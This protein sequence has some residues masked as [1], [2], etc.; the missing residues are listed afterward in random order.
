M[1]FWLLKAPW[2]T[3]IFIRIEPQI[4]D[5]E[6][7][8]IIA[9]MLLKCNVS[10]KGSKKDEYNIHTT[11]HKNNNSYYAHKNHQKYVF[12]KAITRT[13]TKNFLKFL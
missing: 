13:I 2:F 4:I 6:N 3:N 1:L 8:Q 11:I 10:P 5:I 12:T 7:L 9:V